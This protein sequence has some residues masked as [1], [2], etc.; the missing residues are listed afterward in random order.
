MIGFFAWRIYRP[1]T[2]E[3]ERT[4]TEVLRYA[5]PLAYSS[6]LQQ[7]IPLLINAIISRLPD[8]PQ[9]LAAFGVIRGFLF[10]LSGPMRNL[11]QAYLTLVRRVEDNRIINRFFL[12]VASGMAL[13]ML[14]IALPLNRLILGDIMGL[15]AEMRAYI[16]LPLIISAFYP[17][18]YGMTNLLRGV[19][20]GAHRTGMLGRSTIAKSCFMLALLGLTSLYPIPIP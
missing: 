16:V 2:G 8:A 7:T 17:F 20:A 4:T 9:A 1:A 3:T 18:L 19:F 13:I 14:L 15:D 11:Q 12:R 5:F 10:L 6:C